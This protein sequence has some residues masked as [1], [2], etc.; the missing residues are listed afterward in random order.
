MSH[1]FNQKPFP[2]FR[3]TS[4]Y[5]CTNCSRGRNETGLY[6]ELVMKRETENSLKQTS[7]INLH[8]K[9]EIFF[10]HR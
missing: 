10:R 5:I 3:Q 2:T 9:G 4:F 1:D 6:G 8:N 7:K